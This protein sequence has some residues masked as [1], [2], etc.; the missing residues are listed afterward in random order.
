[1]RAMRL[2]ALVIGLALLSGSV[3]EAKRGGGGRGRG[4][5]FNKRTSVSSSAS[6]RASST[7]PPGHAWG[8]RR[9]LG[10]AV[11]LDTRARGRGF[12]VAP[13][14]GQR[15]FRAGR[16]WEFDTS[17]NSWILIP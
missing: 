4:Q 2:V 8:L 7:F 5:G 15:I 16:E 12:P 11:P 10:A 14:D 1:M 3:A 13:L 9:N 17:S 6:V